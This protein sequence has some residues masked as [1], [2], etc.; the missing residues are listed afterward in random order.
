MSPVRRQPGARLPVSVWDRAG[1]VTC[2]GPVR[3]GTR[4]AVDWARDLSWP[5]AASIPDAVIP[6][7][8]TKPRPGGAGSLVLP[9]NRDGPGIA[10][11][12]CMVTP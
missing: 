11:R 8:D 1:L 5:P 4:S 10:Y 9:R 6:N 2:G 12:L 7:P 3:A